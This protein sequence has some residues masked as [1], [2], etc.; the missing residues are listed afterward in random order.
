MSLDDEG[1]LARAV[2]G[3]SRWLFDLWSRVYDFPPVQR[4]TYA[5][6]HDAI[7][8]EL[9]GASV[10]KGWILDV[11]CG[12]GQLAARIRSELPCA[13]VVG[14]DFSGGM[15][16]EASRRLPRGLWTR[17]D[18][19]RLP[20]ASGTFAA[21]VS[22]E[23]FHWFPDQ[24]QALAEMFRVLAPGGR[25]FLALVNVPWAFLGESLRVGSRAVGAPFYWP[26]RAELRKMM[27]ACGFQ[28]VRQKRVFR[29]PAGVLLPPILN[30]GARPTLTPG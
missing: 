3:G 14:V 7:L 17:G 5:P 15:L 13:R 2:G 25:I 27:V 10:E 11:G 4:V 18:A 29:I 12:T 30:S 1:V 23:A 21:V 26:T 16:A 20:F 9:R 19:G 22:S 24:K 8:R 6:V 28:G